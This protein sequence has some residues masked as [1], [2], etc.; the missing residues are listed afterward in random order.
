[1]KKVFA[2]FSALL[3]VTG[4]KAQKTNAQK[5]TVKPLVDSVPIKK[6]AATG[7]AAVKSQ[8]GAKLAPAT[9]KYAP[10]VQKGA[11]ATS[12]AAFKQAAIKN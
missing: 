11:P 12:G 9:I 8:K 1:M 4:L 3:I 7:P 10:A 5:E 6:G 2:I